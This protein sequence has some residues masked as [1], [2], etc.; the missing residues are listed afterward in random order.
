MEKNIVPWHYIPLVVALGYNNP[1]K[2]PKK[3]PT[4]IQ[5]TPNM[6]RITHQN[7][8]FSVTYVVYH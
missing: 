4:F 7:T 5:K 8:I 1:Y 2:I 3:L 6:N